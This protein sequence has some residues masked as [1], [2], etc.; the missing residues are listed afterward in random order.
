VILSLGVSTIVFSA[1]TVLAWW[2]FRVGYKLKP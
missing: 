1:V 2:L